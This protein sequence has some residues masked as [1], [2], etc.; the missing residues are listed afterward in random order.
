MK[1]LIFTSDHCFIEIPSISV[2]ALVSNRK[3]FKDNKK[4]YVFISFA[5][6]DEIY[7]DHLVE[8]SKLNKSPFEFIDMSVKKPWIEEEWRDKCRTKI[9]RCNGIIVLLSKNTWHSSGTRWEIKC[10]KEESVPII[11]M[12]IKKKDKG[13]I[14]P[15]MKG[16]H[17]IEWS[18]KNL[19][20]FIDD[21]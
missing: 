16:I 17:I 7:R 11:G 19:E 1:L 4:K 2:L 10:G 3:N 8:Q 9:K 5:I 14:P 21:L 18:W 20:K 12:H 13:A 15:E 6:E